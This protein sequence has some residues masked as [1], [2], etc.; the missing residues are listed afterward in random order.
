MEAIAS[1]L[2][3]AG[4]LLATICRIIETDR[5]ERKRIRILQRTNEKPWTRSSR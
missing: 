2:A 4:L 3:I 1:I 5:A